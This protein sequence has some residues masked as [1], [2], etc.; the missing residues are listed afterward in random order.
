MSIDSVILEEN[1]E[2]ASCLL[3]NVSIVGNQVG[4][5]IWGQTAIEDCMARGREG[6]R[7]G[8]GRKW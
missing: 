4:L 7:C 2:V 3:K 8:N 5:V 6:R 1:L